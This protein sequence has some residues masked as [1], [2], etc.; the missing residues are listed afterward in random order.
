MEPAVRYYS[1]GDG[2]KKIAE[3][4]SCCKDCR[5]GFR[6]RS[7]NSVLAA[8]FTEK[9]MKSCTEC[10]GNRAADKTFGGNHVF[11]K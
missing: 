10:L 7:Q 11:Y 6:R 1:R 3:A 2:T 4:I 8:D 5:K 9:T